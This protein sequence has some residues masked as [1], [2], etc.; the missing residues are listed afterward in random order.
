MTQDFL[1]QRGPCRASARLGAAFTCEQQFREGRTWQPVGLLNPSFFQF[2][3][4]YLV[5]ANK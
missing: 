4:V 3:E 2:L 5:I 1:A